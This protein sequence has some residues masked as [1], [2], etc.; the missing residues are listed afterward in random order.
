MNESTNEDR[1][2]DAK[3]HEWLFGVTCEMRVC[4]WEEDTREWWEVQTV[5]PSEDPES[6]V[7]GGEYHGFEWQPC[8]YSNHWSAIPNY[9]TDDTAIRRAELALP[10]NLRGEYVYEMSRM[11]Q[12]NAWF[13]HDV[14]D[15]HQESWNLITASPAQ[16]AQALVRVLERV[17]VEV[18]V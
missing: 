2:M 17:R 10:A 3:L 18:G 1:A 16:R 12:R 8:V 15:V 9:T 7:S 4:I 14:P 11:A 13:E 6:L 5:H